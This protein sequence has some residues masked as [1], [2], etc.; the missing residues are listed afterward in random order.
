MKIFIKSAFSK[1][2]ISIILLIIGLCIEKSYSQKGLVKTI[3]RD[4]MVGY[5]YIMPLKVKFSGNDTIFILSFQ[6]QFLFLYFNKRFG[7]S[8]KTFIDTLFPYL[9]DDRAI[10]INDYEFFI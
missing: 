10:E 7:W 1:K 6:T 4:T 3:L 2:M 9:L 5:E 8:G